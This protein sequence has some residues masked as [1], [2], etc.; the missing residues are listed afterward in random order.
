MKHQLRDSKGRF[1][2]AST[3]SLPIVGNNVKV[4]NRMPKKGSI[5]ERCNSYK[6]CILSVRQDQ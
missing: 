4:T 5:C 3:A 2:K 1:V 6:D